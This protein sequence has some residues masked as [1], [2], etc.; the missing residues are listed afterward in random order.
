MEPLLK[1]RRAMEPDFGGWE[2]ERILPEVRKYF[3]EL[4]PSRRMIREELSDIDTTIAHGRFWRLLKPYRDLTQNNVWIHWP[5]NDDH[6]ASARGY[7]LLLPDEDPLVRIA[8]VRRKAEALGIRTRVVTVEPRTPLSSPESP[9]FRIIVNAASREYRVPAGAMILHRSSND[10]R[11]LRRLGI[12]C[13]GI[14]PYLVDAFQTATIHGV[15]E[16]IR[17]DRFERGVELT[18]KIVGRWAAGE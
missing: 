13:Y 18:R 2:P 10:L 8:W 17:L 12:D 14:S 16:Q 7:M 15:D 1:L 4:A 6:G 9:M 3:R 11:Y 5:Q